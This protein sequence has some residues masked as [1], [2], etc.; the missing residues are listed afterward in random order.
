[1]RHAGQVG[2]HHVAGRVLAERH[3]QLGFGALIVLARQQLPNEDLVPPWI[4]DLDPDHGLARNGRQHAHGERPER[5][6]EIVGQRDDAVHLHARGRLELEGRDHRSRSHRDHLAD[7]AEVRELRLE[8]ARAGDEGAF[9]DRRRAAD[10]RVEEGE[11]RQPVR[12]FAEQLLLPLDPLRPL[13]RGAGA[14]ARL[15]RIVEEDGR[16]RPRRPGERR[17]RRCSSEQ[18]CAG[19][20]E[21]HRGAPRRRAEPAGDAARHR[22][23]GHPGGEHERDDEHDG[24]GEGGPRSAEQ[25]ARR[26]AEEATQPPATAHHRP[27][28]GHEPSQR[29]EARD[30]ETRAREPCPGEADRV[31]AEEYDG[32]VAEIERKEIRREAEGVEPRIG[33]RVADRAAQVGSGRARHVGQ[34]AE[35]QEH[36]ERCR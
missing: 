5:H 12:F 10:R 27:P 2:D 25:I 34:K 23:G 30:E 13:R 6:R 19:N 8:D 7:H 22:D 31:M 11:R 36:R 18:T 26:N 1:M 21:L 33:Q 9:L 20:A 28:A 14:L 29:G 16:G 3:R 32:Q 35:G 17:A 4:G 15:D 24:Q